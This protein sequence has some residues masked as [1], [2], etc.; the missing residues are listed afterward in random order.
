MKKK[1]ISSTV[2]M[3]LSGIKFRKRK[4]VPK[5]TVAFFAPQCSASLVH[6][7]GYILH[8]LIF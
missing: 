2:L 1:I 8:V 3:N 7:V 4:M 6:N 5:V